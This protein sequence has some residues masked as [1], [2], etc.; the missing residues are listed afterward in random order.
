MS[1]E[2]ER[3]LEALHDKLTCPPEE[4]FHRIA[5]FERLFQDALA[6]RARS[7]PRSISRRPARPLS[8]LLPRPPQTANDATERVTDWARSL[9]SS[10]NL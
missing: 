1:P 5:T 10:S 8:R 7:Q 9:V 4:K 6:R 3:L 2:L